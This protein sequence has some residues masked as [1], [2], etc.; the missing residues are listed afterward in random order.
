MEFKL[1]KK[2]KIKPSLWNIRKEIN[3]DSIKQLKDSIGSIGLIEPIVVRENKLE[4]G[5]YYITAGYKR[6]KTYKENEQIP[7]IVKDED[8][9]SA[10]IRSLSENIFRT[11]I[12]D[13]D[14]EKTTY[15]IYQQGL[16]EKRW[17]NYTQMSK[18]AQIP[19]QTISTNIQAYKD[20]RKLKFRDHE[21]QPSTSDLHES[22]PLKNKPKARK[23]LIQEKLNSK[24]KSSNHNIHKIAKELKEKTEEDAIKSLEEKV[25]IITKDKTEKQAEPV[26]NKTCEESYAK[27]T[28]DDIKKLS[29]TLEKIDI[30]KIQKS[31]DATIKEDLLS[32][33]KNIRDECNVFLACFGY[34]KVEIEEI[35]KRHKS[36]QRRSLF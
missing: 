30:P 15:D 36:Q 29:S 10:K 8:E 33:L 27:Q 12:S 13:T 26:E 21:K 25:D 31:F 35:D 14:K 2:S 5:T 24:I 23:K 32:E 34:K 9:L 19:V 16:R 6:W 28:I 20:R 3:K 18:D 11:D 4:P 7:C 22:R 17:K 1:I